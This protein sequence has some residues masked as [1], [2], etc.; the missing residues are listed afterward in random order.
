MSLEKTQITDRNIHEFVQNYYENE[1]S[2]LPSDL[3][4]IPI[5]KWDV[6]QVTNMKELF[7]GLTDFNESLNEWNVSNVT[8]MDSMFGECTNFNQP[9]NKWNV[10]NVVDMESMFS[11]CENF[12]QSLNEW[13]S[14]VGNVT[15]MG[16]LFFGCTNFNQPL[17]EWNVINVI[18]MQNMFYYCRKFNQP[19]NQWASKVGN[20]TNMENMFFGCT[21]FNQ[22]LNE[23]NVHN[24]TDMDGIFDEC[25][26]QEE[27]KPIFHNIHVEVDPHQI[28][29]VMANINL[30]LL[31]Q[32]FVKYNPIRFERPSNYGKYIHDT[33]TA[34]IEEGT[35]EATKETQR[36][37][38]RDLM[39]QRLERMGY[40]DYPTK[41]LTTLV[42]ALE[43]VKR[44]PSVF[45]KG[46]VEMFIH[47]CV[48]AYEGTEGMSCAGGALERI[49]TMLA[50]AALL[51]NPEK[52]EYQELI[53]IIENSPSKMIKDH[54][55]P[56]WY[57]LHKKGT[58][59]AFPSGTTSEAKRNNLRA[60]L[61]S[62]L[63]NEGTLIDAKIAEIADNYGY[64]E[65]DFDVLYGG[66]RRKTKKSRRTRKTKKRKP[67][68]KKRK[69][70]KRMN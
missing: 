39:E 29:K 28:H 16:S 53:G 20:V 57:K 64:D 11:Y 30:D 52:E 46:Y 55:I 56:E 44:Q 63:P 13:A 32:F 45:K 42:N 27:N 10:S 23:W 68:N 24:V 48:H 51:T 54:Y 9:L 65:D 25:G 50:P 22:P 7:Q 34:F 49:I 36:Q 8:N 31:N 15:N 70:K 58:E 21:N 59:L 37:G 62:K 67:A 18:D 43:Y 26:I 60:F 69:T 61:L 14:K 3:H 1:T 17:N 5:G 4:E 41:F 19:L 47:D 33:M 12:N 38:L 66:K 40:S 6:S 35:E 2:Y